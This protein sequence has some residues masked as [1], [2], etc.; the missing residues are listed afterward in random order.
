AWHPGI[1]P[2]ARLKEGASIDQ[3]RSEMRVISDR[4]ARAY[5]EFVQ[6]VSADVVPLHAYIVQTV[7]HSLLVLMAAVGFVLLIA[8]ANVANLLLARAV[9]RQREIAIRSALGASR[10]RIVVELMVESLAIAVAGGGAGLLVAL[11]TAPLLGALASTNGTAGSQI[12]IDL[13]VLLF[14]VAIALTTGIVFGLAPALQTTRIDVAAA[15]SEGG[16][17]RSGGTGHH[18]LRGLLVV[19]IGRA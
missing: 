13:T 16:R 2:I 10:G 9:G 19:E 12:G 17:S 6:G 7:R 15:I 18:R 5:P 8:C 11:W 14:T 1:W 4:L 3:A